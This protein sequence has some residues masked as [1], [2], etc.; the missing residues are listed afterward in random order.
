MI[1][2][3][4]VCLVQMDVAATKETQILKTATTAQKRKMT[5]TQKQTT[6]IRSRVE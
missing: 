4:D 3:V 2:F 6:M 5:M 1:L